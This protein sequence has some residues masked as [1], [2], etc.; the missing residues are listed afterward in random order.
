[1]R[2]NIRRWCVPQ[3][4]ILPFIK[5]T[6]QIGEAHGFVARVA[7]ALEMKDGLFRHRMSWFFYPLELKYVSEMVQKDTKGVNF[8]ERDAKTVVYHPR[9]FTVVCVKLRLLLLKN[10]D[11][12][13]NGDIRRYITKNAGFALET[14]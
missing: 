8:W 4:V 3:M 14:E 10:G 11:V 7:R 12:H 2:Y 5:G 1:M 6:S 13:Q 9:F